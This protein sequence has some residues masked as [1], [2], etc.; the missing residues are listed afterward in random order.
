MHDVDGDTRKAGHTTGLW[1]GGART[2]CVGSVKEQNLNHQIQGRC[3]RGGLARPPGPTGTGR[4]RPAPAPTK[5]P[6]DVGYWGWGFRAWARWAQEN[7]A[8]EQEHCPPLSHHRHPRAWGAGEAHPRP[9]TRL[10]IV[11]KAGGRG[12]RARHIWPLSTRH[13]GMDVVGWGGAVALTYTQRKKAWEGGRRASK[14]NLSPVPV[15]FPCTPGAWPKI[16]RTA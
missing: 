10:G 11:C 13:T 1:G 6:V 2:G 5:G 4:A 8:G 3:W 16:S 14:P 9:R 15:S 7:N 12:T